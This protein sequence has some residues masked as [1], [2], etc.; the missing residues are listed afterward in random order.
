MHP[1][2]ALLI[3]IWLRTCKKIRVTVKSSDAAGGG[4]L[5]YTVHGYS[6]Q[7]ASIRLLIFKQSST[8]T[9]SLF[10]VSSHFSKTTFKTGPKC[11]HSAARHF[12]L[13]YALCGDFNFVNMLNLRLPNRS[14]T[15]AAL[16]SA[17]R[18]A[19]TSARLS[20]ALP[21]VAVVMDYA[22][23]NI[24]QMRIYMSIY[25]WTCAYAYT[26]GICSI[27]YDCVC[28]GD[29]ERCALEGAP[30]NTS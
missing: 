4:N 2:V 19:Q 20:A 13:G 14:R 26:R 9:C 24:R 16:N 18:S 25:V 23:S 1:A 7:I 15:R 11:L 10:A 5:K 17:S 6:S 21:V 29:I 8:I 30:G 12:S 22:R 3:A 28:A 27:K